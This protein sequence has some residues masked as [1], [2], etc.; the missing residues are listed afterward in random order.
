MNC[1]CHKFFSSAAFTCDQDGR[2]GWGHFFYETVNVLHR[3]AFADYVVK[4]VSVAYIVSKT[5]V[6]P[7][8]GVMFQPFADT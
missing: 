1:L 6:L 5:L 4:M 3:F 7:E 2:G 8:Q